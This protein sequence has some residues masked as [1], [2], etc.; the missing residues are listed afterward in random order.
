[1][2]SW[3]AVGQVSPADGVTVGWAIIVSC[4][5]VLFAILGGVVQVASKLGVMAQMLTDVREQVRSQ[6]GRH[7]G[8]ATQVGD[9]TR[10]LGV[11]EEQSSQLRRDVDASWK[12]RRRQRI[13]GES[14]Q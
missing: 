7:D 5:A 14:N 3:L 8:L 2:T 11:M 13:D 12:D 1:M 4:G 6:D 9:V 10:K